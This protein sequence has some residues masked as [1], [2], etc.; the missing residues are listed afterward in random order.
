LFQLQPIWQMDATLDKKQ[1]VASGVFIAAMP[2][3]AP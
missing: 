2:G 1:H 3:Y